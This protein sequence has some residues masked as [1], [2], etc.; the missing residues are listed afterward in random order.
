METIS[1]CRNRVHPRT[2][3][4][5]NHRKPV[6][7]TRPASPRIHCSA[8]ASNASRAHA[9]LLSRASA[10]AFPRLQFPAP[11]LSPALGYLP[12][13]SRATSASPKFAVPYRRRW[14]QWC[15]VIS[16]PMLSTSHLRVWPQFPAP[17]LALSCVCPNS[18]SSLAPI[19][20]PSI[21]L[22]PF[23]VTWT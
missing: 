20:N 1:S 21:L 19:P 14:R 10:Q 13:G 11:D 5:G 2:E 23:Q 7:E 12:R 15:S 9:R 3:T 4:H 8:A 18:L 16:S 22:P 6:E 17:A